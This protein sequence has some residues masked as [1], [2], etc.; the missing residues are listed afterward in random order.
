[1]NICRRSRAQ[2]RASPIASGCAMKWSGSTIDWRL[3]LLGA[4]AVVALLGMEIATETDGISP[5]E[6][7]LEVAELALTIGAAVAIA[8]MFGRLRT[9]H[10][11]RLTLTRDLHASKRDGE[12]WRA[13]AQSHLE[14]LSAAIREQFRQW[15]LS[16][17]ESEV[18]LLLM[19]GLSH[20][21]IGLMRGTS[22]ATVRQ[23]AR[24]AYEKSG[25][26]GRA[27][28]C[29]YFLEDLL[30]ARDTPAV[31]PGRGNGAGTGNGM[32]AAIP[33]SQHA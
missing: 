30:P 11:E 5:L 22:E 7:L 15:R 23:Q 20:R 24:A 17:A 14:G 10:E 31:R 6:L 12:H 18:C 27:P 26:K 32:A 3:G 21:E 19:K 29:A 25:L 28:L 33:P 13:Q 9:Q 4:G 8:L 1:M 2:T 16:E